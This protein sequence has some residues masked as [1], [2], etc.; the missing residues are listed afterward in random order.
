MGYHHER[1]TPGSLPEKSTSLETTSATFLVDGFALRIFSS[2]IIILFLSIS[3]FRFF[4]NNSKGSPSSF[5]AKNRLSQVPEGAGRGELIYHQPFSHRQIAIQGSNMWNLK[6]RQVLSQL[7]L[8]P[9]A[10]LA[11]KIID[12]W[13]LIS[14]FASG[15]SRLSPLKKLMSTLD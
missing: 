11:P 14:G 15:I 13:W 1:K 3:R 8:A 12:A 5:S 2:T 9:L 7:R 10:P 6:G 4:S